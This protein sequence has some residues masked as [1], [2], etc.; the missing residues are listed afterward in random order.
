MSTL[1]PVT[2]VRATSAAL[3]LRP[4][5]SAAWNWDALKSSMVPL[6]LKVALRPSM[7]SEGGD[8]GGKGVVVG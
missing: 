4:A 1:P 2:L 8:V 6:T 5:A 3:R 7:E